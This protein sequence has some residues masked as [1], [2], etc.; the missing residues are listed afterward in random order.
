V[1]AV[2]CELLLG[3][4]QAADPFGPADAVEWPPHPYRLHAA[5]VAA[6]SEAGGERP[7]EDALAALRWLEQQRPPSITCSPEPSGRTVAASWV[8]RNP[9]RGTEWK[10]DYLD[11]GRRIVRL[12]RSFPTAIPADPAVTFTWPTDDRAP[13]ALDA[14]PQTHLRVNSEGENEP[15]DA[16]LC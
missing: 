4:Y 15:G 6:A 1:F 16:L 7:A 13:V 5:L 2:R 10:R 3:S 11:K 9:T 12:D 14:L 8:P